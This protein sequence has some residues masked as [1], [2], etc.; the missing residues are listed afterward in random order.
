MRNV[1]FLS[2][3]FLSYLCC[4]ESTIPKNQILYLVQGGEIE[5]GVQLYQ[6]YVRER[7]GRHDFPTLEQM[8]YILIHQGARDSDEECK[9]LSMYGLSIAGSSEGMGLY[10]IGMNSKN[11]IVQLSTIQFLSHIQDDQVEPLLLK[12]FS[13][14]YI[15]V[16]MEAAYVLATRRSDRV[17]GMIHS[18][19]LRLPP[20]LHVY[21]PELFGMIGTSDAI[22]VLKQMINA[23][24][25][26]V[27]LA[28]IFAAAKFG[29]DDFLHG[30]RAA[31]THL[32]EAEQEM[33]AAALGYLKDSHSIPLLKSLLTSPSSNVRLAACQSLAMLGDHSFHE[34]VIEHAL[35]KNLLAIPM[36]T[37]IPNTEAIL[38]SL[39]KDDNLQIRIN[40]ALALL[41]KRDARCASTLLTVLLKDEQDLG[42][43]PMHSLGGAFMTWKIIPSCTQYAK[44]IQE[45]LSSITLS[46]RE[47]IL[48]DSLELP[49][50]SFLYIAR[51]IF[52]HK[53]NDLIPLLVRLLENLNTPDAIALLQEESLRAGAPFIRTYCHLALFRMNGNSPHKDKLYKWIESR[54]EHELI[55]FRTTLSW[56]ERKDI[57]THSTFQ[58][59]PK[60]TSLLLIEAFE[61]LAGSHDMRGIDILLDSIRS[62]N[63]KNRYAL[64][65]LLLKAIQ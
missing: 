26:E 55:R 13:S 20:C 47:Q 12:A 30:I 24:H 42:F 14:S 33:C 62:G 46:L 40:S 4:G 65:G 25:L 6:D 45:D 11:P 15:S 41:K 32:D 31:A 52:L 1:F 28:A 18:F 36:L 35:H 7:G 44:Q 27:R 22:G 38:L 56:I 51:K 53:Q 64:A 10:E 16:M 5:R 48:L 8:G 59:S 23:P 3:F 61:T 21:F 37:S 60:E 2:F 9:L 17:T 49:E 57:A 54:K 19:M 50:E 29:R 43:R 63:R 58:L 39:L 34:L